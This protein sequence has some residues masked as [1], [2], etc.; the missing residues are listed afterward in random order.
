MQNKERFSQ[1]QQWAKALAKDKILMMF[2]FSCVGF[3]PSIR[4]FLRLWVLTEALIL[5]MFPALGLSIRIFLKL[6]CILQLEGLSQGMVVGFHYLPELV[7][8]IDNF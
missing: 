5:F 3:S 8:F 1:D 2:I 6:S 7:K 4:L